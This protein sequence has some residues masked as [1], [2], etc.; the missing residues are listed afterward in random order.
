MEPINWI[1]EAIHTKE[2]VIFTERELGIPG[3][4]M[5]GKHA[6]SKAIPALKIHYHANCFEFTCI[7]KGNIT[8]CVNDLSYKISGGDVFLTYPN[9]TH[10]TGSKPLSLH[11]MFWF[12]IDISN[13]SSFFF[14]Q[15]LIAQN[16][17]N[18]LNEITERVIKFDAKE[19]SATL[20]AIFQLLSSSSFYKRQEGG[21]L[22]VFFLYRILDNSEIQS[23]K[24]TPDILNTI[25]Y[26]LEHIE[27]EITLEQLAEISM[28]S[29]S[30]FKV[31]FK[32][33]LGITPREFINN[34]KIE[35]AKQ[36]LLEGNSVTDTAMSL[37]FSSSNY[38]SVVFKQFSGFTPSQYVK[39]NN[40]ALTKT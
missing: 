11:E 33:Q 15:P 1:D 6:T 38:F 17:I 2:R 25:N 13:P 28:L 37:G 20:S 12:Q 36:M 18:R 26:V 3:L 19:A 31:K 22:L 35:V 29:I 9:E 4:R 39:K 10:H 32:A 27:D 24:L 5:F 23:F 40:T 7:M 21:M 34:E 8:F 14:L 16:L 30:R